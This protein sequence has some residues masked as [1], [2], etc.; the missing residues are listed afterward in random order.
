MESFVPNE[1]CRTDSIN[2]WNIVWAGS[3]TC[4]LEKL[5]DLQE[6]VFS[7]SHNKNELQMSPSYNSKE[8]KFYLSKKTG[9]FFVLQKCFCMKPLNF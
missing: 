2:L 3:E 8:T 7:Y 6:Q 1:N 5:F 4:S 9:F